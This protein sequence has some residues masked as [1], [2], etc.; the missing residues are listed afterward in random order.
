MLCAVTEHQSHEQE[1]RAEASKRYVPS[2]LARLHD[3]LR[4]NEEGREV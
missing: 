2:E 3:I 4:G 1:Q